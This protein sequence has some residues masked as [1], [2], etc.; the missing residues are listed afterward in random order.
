MSYDRTLVN[1]ALG[2]RMRGAKRGEGQDGETESADGPAALLGQTDSCAGLVG[3][4]R[5]GRVSRV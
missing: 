1:P 3:G 2:L 4:R 5:P